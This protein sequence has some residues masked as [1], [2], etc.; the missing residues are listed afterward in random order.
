MAT[1]KKTKAKP[2]TSAT[3]TS[4]G[5]RTRR[6]RVPRRVPLRLRKQLKVAKPPLPSAWVLVQQTAAILRRN[7]KFFIL[8]SLLYGVLS[9]L[10]VQSAG[11][12]FSIIQTKELVGDSFG[13]ALPTSLALY[14]GLISNSAQLNNQV[15]A[16]Y[17]FIIILVFSLAAIYALRHMYGSEARR[18]H[19]KEA[20]YRGMTPLVPLLLVVCVL[21]LE[22]L[23]LSIGSSLYVAV[24]NGGLAVGNVEQAIWL[25]LLLVSAGITIYLWVTSVMAL[26][27]V[28][29]P[30]MTPMQ[31]LRASRELARFRRW[32]ILRKLIY[33]PLVLLLLLGLVVVPLIA[34]LPVLAQPIFFGLS[35]LI[36]PIVLTYLYNLYRSML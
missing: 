36:L 21:V 32:S 11:S 29:L 35:A 25:S 3:S 9:L 12:G 23:P 34:W 27:I 14:G 28:T 1:S 24:S 31:A 33:M 10:F 26:F 6:V 2:K 19:V 5:G 20:L 18:V 15:A 17:Q 4:A 30:D 8:Y 7:K 16:L 22:L 13:G